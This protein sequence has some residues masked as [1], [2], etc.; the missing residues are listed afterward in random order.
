MKKRFLALPA[1]L[2]VL[3]T[4]AMPALAQQALPKPSASTPPPPPGLYV[5]VIDGLVTLSN[6][7]GTQNFAAG[8]F[9]FTPTPV[10]API[11]VP[12]NPG[13]QFTPPPAFS[14]PPT[15]TG[16]ASAPKPNAVDCEVR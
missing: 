13:I 16:S 9:G 14:A 12:K 15:V 3:V 4:A 11:V 2:A 1:A 10:Q 7:G 5:Q 6:R 8:Q